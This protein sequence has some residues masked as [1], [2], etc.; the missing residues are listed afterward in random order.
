MGPQRF[1]SLTFNFSGSRREGRL[2]TDVCSLIVNQNFIL[3]LKRPLGTIICL[4]YLDHNRNGIHDP[5]D[6]LAGNVSFCLNGESVSFKAQGLNAA[7][8]R[9]EANLI[10]LK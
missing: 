7:A 1:W 2:A 9:T 4:A 8:F 5:D 3:P 6:P 10:I